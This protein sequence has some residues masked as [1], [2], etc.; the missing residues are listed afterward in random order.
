MK[1][2]EKPKDFDDE[3][4]REQANEI[5]QRQKQRLESENKG[6]IVAIEVKSN[7]IFIADTVVEAGMK[8]RLKYPEK[9]FYFKRIG[10]EAVASIRSYHND[11]QRKNVHRYE[12]H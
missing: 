1:V 10:Y 5:Y 7:D 11:K 8:A 12:W 6:K 2:I 3:A 9:F 4:F